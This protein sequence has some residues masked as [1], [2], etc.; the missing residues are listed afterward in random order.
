MM[1]RD[2]LIAYAPYFSAI[3]TSLVAYLGYRETKRK[4]RHDE[5]R[6]LYEERKKEAAE[7]KKENLRLKKE[8]EKYENE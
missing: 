8:L 5:L 2:V 7:L 6:E 4:S 1:M 3:V